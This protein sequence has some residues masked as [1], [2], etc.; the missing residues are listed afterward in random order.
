MTLCPKCKGLMIE[1][2]DEGTRV[3]RCVNCG[4]RGLPEVVKL[5]PGDER[6][7]QLVKA[8]AAVQAET[9]KNPDAVALGRLGGRKGGVARAEALSPERRSEIATQAAAARWS[10]TANG[11]R[12]ALSETHRQKIREG[13]A[14][15]RAEGKSTGRPPEKETQTLS[16]SA[17]HRPVTDTAQAAI[18]AIQVHLDRIGAEIATLTREQDA[19]LQ[20]KAILSRGR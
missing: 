10:G 4:R 15:A 20:A 2:P 13:I 14:R 3:Y 16:Q 18:A 19:L 8:Q 7:E 1:A 6:Q 9:G 12:P 11:K 5:L 17:D